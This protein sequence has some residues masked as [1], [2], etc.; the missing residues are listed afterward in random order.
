MI[1]TSSYSFNVRG[2]DILHL[3]H[4]RKKQS[5][6]SHWFYISYIFLYFFF[7]PIF[8]YII[9]N[10][11]ISEKLSILRVLCRENLLFDLM[12][13]L[14]HFTNFSSTIIL[15]AAGERICSKAGMLG[16]EAWPRPRGQ[17]TWPRPR[18]RPRGLWPR[19]RPRPRGVWPRPR[20]F[21]PRA[22]RPLEAYSRNGTECD[23][24]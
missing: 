16:L 5:Q 20:G 10:S 23:W 6:G 7:I 21:W 14:F 9:L 2:L 8:S 18:P 24:K 3:Q 17:K 4:C 22:S 11:Y 13:I 19:P 12:Q 1:I 15:S